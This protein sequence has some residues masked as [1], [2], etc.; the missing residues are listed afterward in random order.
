MAQ[1]HNDQ[2]RFAALV[3]LDWADQQHAGA[4]RTAAD[5]AL[6]AFK[7]LQTADAIEQWAAAL[8]R[9]FSG[10][11]VAICLEQS[12]G[13]LVY[14]LLKYDFIV[15]F[16]VNPKQ[17]ARF[18]EAMVSSGAKG[19]PEDAMLLLE[20]LCKHRQQLRAWQPD[21]ATTRL[22]GQLAEDRRNLVDHGTRLS[23]ALKSRLK[24]YF[25]WRWRSWANWIRSSPVSFFCGGQP[26]KS[27]EAPNRRRSPHSIGHGIATIHD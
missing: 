14:A 5:G 26:S 20:L 23:N 8:R 10:R 25:R 15:L 6:E 7:L 12:K 18:R 21:D 2:D 17:L 27:C 16:P 9:R 19:D 3:G 1:S 11:P 24:Q 4:L 22:I 13:A